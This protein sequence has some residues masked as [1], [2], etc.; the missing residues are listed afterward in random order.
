MRRKVSSSD[1]EGPMS[2][3]STQHPAVVLRS[4]Y[5]HVRALLAIALLA[6]MGL[7]VALVLLATSNA[8]TRTTAAAPTIPRPQPVVSMSLPAGERYD[9]GPDEGSRGP[10]A[11][12]LPSGIRYDGGPDE[13]TVGPGH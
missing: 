1:Q 10:T 8:G 6:V 5:V 4:Q 2:H 13:G 9:G 11:P 7:T 12:P 3:V